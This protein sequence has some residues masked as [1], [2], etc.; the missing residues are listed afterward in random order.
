M[1]PLLMNQ[2]F[3][4]HFSC[5]SERGRH[6]SLVPGICRY[7][8]GVLWEFRGDSDKGLSAALELHA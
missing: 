8:G 4:S 5:P 7:V 1:H 3:R 6:Y 2:A